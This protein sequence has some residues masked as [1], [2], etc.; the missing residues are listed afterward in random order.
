MH[1]EGDVRWTFNELFTLLSRPSSTGR[2]RS[3]CPQSRL[4]SSLGACYRQA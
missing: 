3:V 1:V 4:I 2:V